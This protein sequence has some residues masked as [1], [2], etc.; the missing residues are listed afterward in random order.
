MQYIRWVFFELFKF[1]LNKSTVALRSLVFKT[2]SCSLSVFMK[3]EGL[4]QVNA[5]YLFNYLFTAVLPARSSN[6]GCSG[7]G[8][9]GRVLKVVVLDAFEPLQV[10]N[11][12]HGQRKAD[13][14]EYNAHVEPPTGNTG[15][16]NP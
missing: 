1:L 3:L 2:V 6:K 9:N 16:E 10:H 8:R 14:K 4:H 11:A 12:K 5:G 7:D 15:F 13:P